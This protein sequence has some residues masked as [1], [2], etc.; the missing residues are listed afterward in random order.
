MRVRDLSKATKQS[1]FAEVARRTVGPRTFEE[2]LE[3]LIT[4]ADRNGVEFDRSWEFRD[5][6]EE[7][8]EEG[9]AVMVEIT[10]L[11]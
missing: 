11:E 6:G 4:E 8:E 1:V 5:E 9:T 7:E 10:Y 3:R 2:L